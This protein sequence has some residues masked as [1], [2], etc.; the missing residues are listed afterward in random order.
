MSMLAAT[1]EKLY[2]LNKN[3]FGRGDFLKLFFNKPFYFNW[4]YVITLSSCIEPVRQ[5]FQ[6][7]E[8]P[9]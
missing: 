3:D 6:Q 1:Q 5:T 7:Q 4:L 2:S 8:F 9:H